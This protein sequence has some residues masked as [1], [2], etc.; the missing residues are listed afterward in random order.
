MGCDN[1]FSWLFNNTNT[2]WH[3][4][5]DPVELANAI[6]NGASGVTTNPVLSAQ[7]SQAN[8]DIDGDVK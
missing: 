2:T 6:V 3:D 1:Y 8:K 5:G 7:S 4:C